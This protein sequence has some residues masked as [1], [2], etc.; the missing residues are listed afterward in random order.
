MDSLTVIFHRVVGT[1]KLNFEVT[2]CSQS[3]NQ[4]RSYARQKSP[5]M[6][7]PRGAAGLYIR[8]TCVKEAKFK[9]WCYVTAVAK[10]FP[11][12]KWQKNNPF[13]GEE[14]MFTPKVPYGRFYFFAHL[15]REEVVVD[16]CVNV[17]TKLSC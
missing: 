1:K 13:L 10:R 9:H 8:L 14:N 16:F 15:A 4:A 7:I 12:G 11:W 17:L 6:T 5:S 3:Y 2:I